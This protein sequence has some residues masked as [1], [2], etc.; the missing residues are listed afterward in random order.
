MSKKITGEMLT[1]EGIRSALEL[2]REQVSRF[3]DENKKKQYI[4]GEGSTGHLLPLFYI[5]RFKTVAKRLQTRQYNVWLAAI[6]LM[7]SLPYAAQEKL[8]RNADKQFR[9]LRDSTPETLDI[10]MLESLMQ[11]FTVFAESVDNVLSRNNKK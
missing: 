6:A 3:E 2:L 10:Q 7:T 1:D 11:E 4:T 8:V 9:L 5:K